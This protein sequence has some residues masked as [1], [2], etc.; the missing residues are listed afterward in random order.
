MKVS[1]KEVKG[2]LKLNVGDLVEVSVK[3]SKSG[4][5]MTLVQYVE[6]LQSGGDS[7]YVLARL[8]G[9]GI[10]MHKIETTG[11]NVA[12][13][14]LTTNMLASNLVNSLTITD[15]TVYPASQ[16]NLKLMPMPW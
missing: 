2:T 3:D 7:R 8:D 5:Y 9:L 6:S 13:E 14:G 1:T 4:S 12:L 15:Y 10:I 11:T 16:F